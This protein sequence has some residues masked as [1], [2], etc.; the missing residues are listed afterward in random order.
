MGLVLLKPSS[1]YRIFQVNL[2]LSTSTRS[3]T[4][5]RLTFNILSVFMLVN[6]S[7]VVWGCGGLQKDGTYEATA[8]DIYI[9][10]DLPIEDEIIREFLQLREAVLKEIGQDPATG[11]YH[12]YLYGK[13][14]LE[15]RGQTPLQKGF[16][17]P[18]VLVALQKR[19]FESEPLQV[20]IDRLV[21]EADRMGRNVTMTKSEQGW[22][23]T[24]YGE[25]YHVQ[26]VSQ[27]DPVGQCWITIWEKFYRL[28]KKNPAPM[29]L[30]R[31]TIENQ[32][33]HE[34]ENPMMAPRYVL[35]LEGEGGLKAQS[36]IF[37]QAVSNLQ[38]DIDKEQQKPEVARNTNLY[39]AY[40][41]LYNDLNPCLEKAVVDRRDRIEPGQKSVEYYVVYG[42]Q[43]DIITSVRLSG[44]KLEGVGQAL[45]EKVVGLIQFPLEPGKTTVLYKGFQPFDIQTDLKGLHFTIGS[46]FVELK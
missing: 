27:T 42:V 30:L 32:S 37:A 10:L 34:L 33:D 31:F 1:W 46:L 2:N 21:K 4:M 35:E 14:T 12:D 19:S 40:A 9:R 11:L 36:V 16:S 39:N 24:F 28:G 3:V 20:M 13:L 7:L 8:E 45:Y 5:K 44:G 23:H 22:T 25:T 38:R 18:K 6:I 43:P 17:P 41:L 15:N 29:T 26:T